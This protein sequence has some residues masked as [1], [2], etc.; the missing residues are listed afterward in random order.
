MIHDNFI[1]KC[2][3][4]LA[5]TVVPRCL[6]TATI[7]PVTKHSATASLNDFHPVALTPIMVS[8]LTDLGISTSLYNWTLDILT[9]RPQTPVCYVR[10]PHLLHPDPEHWGPTRLCA[11]PPDQCMVSTLA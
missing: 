8:K 7:E 11:E 3:L 2:N 6:K 1:D 9:C 10:Q 5:Q 4:S